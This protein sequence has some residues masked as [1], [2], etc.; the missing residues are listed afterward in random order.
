MS[1]VRTIL[2]VS[3][4][5]PEES[6]GGGET[7]AYQLYS[8]LSAVP[9]IKSAFLFPLGESASKTWRGS[10]VSQYKR[11]AGEYCF[12]YDADKLTAYSL[13][14]DSRTFST[15]L[16]Q[17]L[18]AFLEKMRPDVVHFHHYF[19]IG[20]GLFHLV[21]RILP[22]ALTCLTLHDIKAICPDNGY[23][24]RRHEQQWP[25]GIRRLCMN[26]STD[27]CLECCE[28]R[29]RVE[30]EGRLKSVHAMLGTVDMF[31]VPSQFVL[32][33]YADWG[34]PRG[35][36]VHIKNGIDG[37]ALKQTA[38]PKR[39]QRRDRFAF[40][41]RNIPPK[42]LEV[43]LNAIAHLDQTGGFEA[44]FLINSPNSSG[45]YRPSATVER[46][47]ARMRGNVLWLGGYS[48]SEL[49]GRMAHTDWVVVPSVWWEN[50]PLVI[51]EAFICGRPVIVSDVGGMAENVRHGIDGLHFRVGDAMDL[52]RTFRYAAAADRLWERLASNLPQ[53]PSVE[54][55]RDATLALYD[56]LIGS[57]PR[58]RDAGAEARR[59]GLL[60]RAGPAIEVARS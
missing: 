55:N 11:R 24:L 26:S 20:D 52:A 59:P 21:R 30:L 18:A 4:N 56:S 47:S 53:P 13:F 43:M 50:S 49:G 60:D 22:R 28:D 10:L 57:R 19:R 12:P 46:L 25:G 14:S 16:A 35:H 48:R 36:L 7:C 5:H 15:P 51:Q 8:S 34:I 23:M 9:A 44:T 42:G 40:F 6:A 45:D 29:S 3:H 38:E 17:A 58:P 33:R 1:G 2:V 41:G 32:E 31:I 27:R 37:S 54:S 39:R